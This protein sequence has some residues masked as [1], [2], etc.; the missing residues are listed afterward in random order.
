MRTIGSTGDVVLFVHGWMMS[1]AVFD[2]LL[3]HVHG[4]GRQLAMVDLRGAG[5][6][7]GHPGPFTVE[8]YVQ[9]LVDALDALGA[10]RATIVGHSMGG[11]LA[12][13]LAARHPAR[14]TGVCAVTPVPLAGLAL[15]E[16]IRSLF[17]SAGGDRA[18]LRRIIDM[19]TLALDD[20]GKDALVD[21]A[22][23]V[24]PACVSAALTT[25]TTGVADA[26]RES[27][28]IT[29]PVLVVATDDPFT[30]PAMLQ[31]EIV[32]RVAPARLVRVTGPGHYPQRE[33]PAALAQVI[34][35]FIAR[36][37]EA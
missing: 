5:A 7:R 37:R 30:P 4:E 36:E 16:P 2:P 21:I 34:N 33:A 18:A 32:A 22:M 29:A 23:T 9:D 31:R 35:G 25:W 17:G 12:L 19:A 8:A 24:A 10:A 3:G 28:A 1:G 27:A 20:A 11:M 6:R 14:V 15:P 13:A 26:V